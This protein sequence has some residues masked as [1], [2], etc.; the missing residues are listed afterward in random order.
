MQDDDEDHRQRQN[1]IAAVFV[2]G[3]VVFSVWLLH[4][5]QQ[6]RAISDCVLSGRH[7]CASAGGEDQ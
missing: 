3:L 4:K 6:Y 5:Y 2:I 1:M 7:N